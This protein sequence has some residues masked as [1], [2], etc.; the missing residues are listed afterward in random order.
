MNE[1]SSGKPDTEKYCD[2]LHKAD[3]VTRSQ[4]VH[5]LENVRNRHQPY[6]S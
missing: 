2:E 3:A 5:V 1:A 4:D 6:C